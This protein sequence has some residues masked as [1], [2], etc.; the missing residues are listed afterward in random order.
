MLQQTTV[1][2]VIPYF[3]RFVGRWPTVEALAASD[4]EDVL[5]AWAGLGYYARARNLHKCARAVVDS[6]GGRFPETEHELRTL[7]GLG[8]YTAA[9]VA[10]IA[11]DRPAVVVD[12][13][14]ERV[15]A[16]LFAVETPLP[17]AKSELREL[18]GN[19]SPNQRPGDYAQAVMDLGATI[20]TPTSPKCLLCPLSKLCEAH[21]RG[22]AESLPRRAAKKAKPTRRGVAFWVERSD[23]AVLFR[24]RPPRGLLGGMVEVPSTEWNESL[25][26]ADAVRDQAPVDAGAWTPLPGIVR[27]SFTHF[28]LELSV[29]HT[30]ADHETDDGIWCLPDRFGE[31]G[32]PSLMRKVTAH[33][34][35]A[36]LS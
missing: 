27:H 34:L 1:A 10:A 11:F 33:A 23:G 7:P 9:A 19:L 20:C 32:L 4:V 22:D 21:A 26:D 29:L 35:A 28:H 5:A 13:N 17:A 2:A 14:V 25:P 15:M 6:H 8:Q 30:K 24:R 16:R 36:R 18:A 31:L 3:E 12:G